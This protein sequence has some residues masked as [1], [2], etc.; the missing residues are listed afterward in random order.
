MLEGLFDKDDIPIVGMFA[1]S[2][3]QLGFVL[4]LI[5][6]AMFLFFGKMRAL[7]KTV[8]DG[9]PFIPD[10]AQR[11]NA[12]AWLVLGVQVLAVPVAGLRQHLASLVGKAG[13]SGPLIDIGRDDLVGVLMVVVLFILARVFRH[14]T[15][16]R[17]ELEGTV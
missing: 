9:D 1:N 2:G 8:G 3:R 10:N 17:E 14:G 4:A 12:M 5:L 13:A 7:I 16:L 11:L 6:T 15:R